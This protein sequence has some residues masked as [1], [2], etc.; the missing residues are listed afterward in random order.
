[1]NMDKNTIKIKGYKLLLDEF[2]FLSISRRTGIRSNRGVLKIRSKWGTYIY[3]KN[4]NSLY[5]EPDVHFIAYLD[6][7]VLFLYRY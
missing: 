5:F 2:Q 6:N 1:M 3:N 7:T 4:N